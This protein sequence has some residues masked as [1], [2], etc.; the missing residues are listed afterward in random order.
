MN[1]RIRTHVT[2]LLIAVS[3]VALAGCS[4]S[5][6]SSQD[7][8]KN[9]ASASTPASSTPDASS[10]SPSADPGAPIVAAYRHYWDEKV[11]A[12]AKASVQ[13]TQL[14]KYA[15]ADAYAAA[16]TEVNSLKT[17]GL[18]ATGRPTLSPKVTSV[19][20]NRKV[21]QGSLTDCTDVSQWKLVKTSTDQE[22]ALPKGRRTK[23]VTNAVAEKWYGQWVIIK[24]TP[25]NQAC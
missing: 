20:T 13:G 14:K 5:K 23:Y 15:V 9:T 17:K 8:A 18:V 3:L 21:P 2:A 4:D 12:Y 25:E 1:V 11:A 6:S 16:E 24:V 19:D 7:N 22:V 10:A